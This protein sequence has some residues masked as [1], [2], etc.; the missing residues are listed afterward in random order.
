MLTDDY[1]A[2]GDIDLG[3]VGIGCGCGFVIGHDQLPP[4][5]LVVF[6]VTAGAITGTLGLYPVAGPGTGPRFWAPR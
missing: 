3:V 4:R 1:G 6:I 2:A 5:A